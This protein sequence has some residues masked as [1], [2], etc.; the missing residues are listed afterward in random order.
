MITYA[1]PAPAADASPAAAGR[2]SERKLG[3]MTS[4]A[5]P[6]ARSSAVICFHP[7]RFLRN[8]AEKSITKNGELRC[9]RLASATF[10]FVVA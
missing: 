8:I 6:N 1:A 2:R 7:R 3:S 5:P 10:M 4:T 9:R